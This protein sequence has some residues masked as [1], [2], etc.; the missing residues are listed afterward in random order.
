MDRD[1]RY[2]I[3]SNGSIVTGLPITLSASEKKEMIEKMFSING[4]KY[5]LLEEVTSAHYFIELENKNLNIK[6]QFHLFHGNVRK[7]DPERNREE[8]KIQLGTEN[9]PREYY[10]NALILGFYVYDR[11]ESLSDIVVVAWPVEM[12]KNYPANPSLRVNMRTEIIPAKNIGYYIDKTTGK[13]LVVFR[14]EFIY[15]YIENYK[16]IQYEN[17]SIANRKDGLKKGINKIYYG[18]PGTGKSFAIDQ[19]LFGIPDNNKFR[20]TFHPEYTYSDFVGQLI[21]K[22]KKDENGNDEITYEFNKGPFT[23][24]MERAY[25]N[26]SEM[27]Y[28][29]IEEMS[30]GN[31]AAIFGD[32]F[33]LL[34]RES[35]G[36]STYFINNEIIAKDIDVIR[37]NHIK[38]PSNLTIL[39]TVNTSDQNVYV[40]DTAFKR[41]FEWKYIPITP[42]PEDDESKKY[43]NNADIE[44]KNSDEVKKYKWVDFYMALNKFISSNEYLGLGEDKQIGQFFIKFDFEEEKDREKI[45]NKLLHYLW[46]DIQ[47]SSFK[48]DKKLFAEKISDFGDLFIKYTTNAQI[49]SDEFFKLLNE[50]RWEK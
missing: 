26:S 3:D 32:V 25:N 15:F 43:K 5:T 28:L 8:K 46:F 1:E 6:K 9:D 16:K 37:D 42:V 21:P 31:C 35:N 19:D 39:G 4:W 20:I 47:E 14:P 11:K 7:E 34:D 2:E 49:F 30:R 38:I 41:R 13:N 18:A 22:V 23:L 44:L 27:I 45:E 40:M 29:I 36:E 17:T 12:E 48:S 50:Y 24:A 33:Q 10:D